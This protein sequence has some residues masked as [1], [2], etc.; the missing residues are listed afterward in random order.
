MGLQSADFS[1][2]GTSACAEREARVLRSPGCARE[3]GGARPH[4][5]RIRTEVPSVNTKRAA[6]VPPA[7]PAHVTNET[8][9][10][11]FK[12]VKG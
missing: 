3:G 9:N 4:Q 1:G 6:E 11:Q 2:T 7:H 12:Q 5:A 8:E 10:S